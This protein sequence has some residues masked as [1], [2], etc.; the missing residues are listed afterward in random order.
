MTVHEREQVKVFGMVCA[1]MIG[2]FVW[3]VFTC[4]PIADNERWAVF[5]MEV[6][7]AV[8]PAYGFM[9]LARFMQG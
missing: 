7:A 9:R 3:S 4:P 2:G 6:A 1:W 8:L 5:G